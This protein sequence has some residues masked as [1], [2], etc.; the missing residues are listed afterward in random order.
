MAPATVSSSIS[1][2]PYGLDSIDQMPASLLN[3]LKKH[4]QI[5]KSIEGI[6]VIPAGSIISRLRRGPPPLQ[7]L[8]FT[9]DG[10]LHVEEPSAR[11]KEG[12]VQWIPAASI[13]TIKLNLILLYESL[14]IWFIDL[15]ANSKLEVEYNTVGHP[16]L[17]PM[18]RGLIRKTWRLNKPEFA[19]A[20]L[21][22][23]FD[24]LEN[25]SY[26]FYNGLRIEA[27]QAEEKVLGYVYQLEIRVPWL[28]VFHR[29]LS[30]QTVIAVT[31][32]QII[33]L[34]QDLKL[35]THH[36]WIITFCPLYRV[37]EVKNEAFKQWQKITFHLLPF[38]QPHIEVIVGTKNAQKW[39]KIW[40]KLTI[41]KDKAA[42]QV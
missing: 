35:K 1:T 23:S 32:Q 13:I 5:D 2:R 38:D 9:R 41:K 20:P 31:N 27:L 15:G 16:I 26:S 3:L 34:Q 30:P 21:D 8:V 29:S 18:L 33:L 7:A 42:S 6:F 14:E 36:E 19:D 11:R 40:D 28:K 24:D 12:R 22:R 39:S 17:S 10:V 25:I 37:V 4:S